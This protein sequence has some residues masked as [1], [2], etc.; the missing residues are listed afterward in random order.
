MKNQIFFLHLCAIRSKDPMNF[1]IAFMMSLFYGNHM[2]MP[3]CSGTCGLT[4]VLT[5]CVVRTRKIPLIIMIRVEILSAENSHFTCAFSRGCG[6]SVRFIEREISRCILLPPV[7]DLFALNL[8]SQ[9]PRDAS[10]IFLIPDSIFESGIVAKL[11]LENYTDLL[12]I[13]TF[14]AFRGFNT[15]NSIIYSSHVYCHGL[16]KPCF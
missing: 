2:I 4:L 6:R 12:I 11:A 15:T 9:S 13:Q 10:R 5:R 14:G 8:V 1:L 16:N 7:S 3:L